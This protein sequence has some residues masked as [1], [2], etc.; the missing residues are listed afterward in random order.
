M[1]DQP[2]LVTAVDDAEQSAVGVGKDDEVGI[3]RVVP[4]HPRSA[5]RQQASDL[6]RLLRRA[7][8]PQIEV[9]A[10]GVVEVQPRAARGTWSQEV[11]IVATVIPQRLAPERPRAL[12]VRDVQDEGTDAQHQLWVTTGVPIGAQS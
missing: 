5:E 6:R 10:I 7:I 1:T 11:G 9:R 2:P 4:L 8:G 12:A 3:L